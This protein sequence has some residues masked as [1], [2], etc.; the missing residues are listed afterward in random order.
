MVQMKEENEITYSNDS[1]QC[2]YLKY[3]LTTEKGFNIIQFQRVKCLDIKRNPLLPPIKH[4]VLKIDP[5]KL[6]DE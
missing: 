5:T 1:L 6:P 4:H 2:G 3:H